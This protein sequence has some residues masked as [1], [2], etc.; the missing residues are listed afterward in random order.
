MVDNKPTE[1]MM[2]KAVWAYKPVAVGNMEA[3]AVAWC[4]LY[5]SAKTPSRILYN[6]FGQTT[7]SK[8]NKKIRQKAIIT[9]EKGNA[10][11]GVSALAAYTDVADKE[12]VFRIMTYD[13]P[14][15]FGIKIFD[16][17]DYLEAKRNDRL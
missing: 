17:E 10:L 12:L 11:S 7:L 15:R 14:D 4:V 2:G 1:E 6:Y 3:G 5:Y 9:L 8:I 16:K 13:F